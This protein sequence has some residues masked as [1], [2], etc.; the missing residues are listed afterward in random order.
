M[1]IPPAPPPF[2]FHPGQL[3]RLFN[4]QLPLFFFFFFSLQARVSN[5]ET[6]RFRARNEEKGRGEKRKKG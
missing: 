6:S 1:Q 4:L 5:D 2:L 3:L